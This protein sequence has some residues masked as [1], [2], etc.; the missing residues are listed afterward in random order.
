MPWRCVRY[1]DDP[2][3]TTFP[4]LICARSLWQDSEDNLHSLFH[5]FTSDPSP[6]PP[7][8]CAGALTS[9]HA[10]SGDGGL[11]WTRAATPP[12][13]NVVAMSGGTPLVVATRERPKLVLDAARTPVALFT[14][15]SALQ[16][17]PPASCCNCKVFGWSFTLAQE[18]N[19]T[20]V[21]A[22]RCIEET[23]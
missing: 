17:C 3:T 8:T 19:L 23:G 15:A 10:F 12:F 5:A 2:L 20:T 13:G 21:G 11:T 18:T 22:H 9:A 6:A 14:G 1:R 4:P 16:T 7:G